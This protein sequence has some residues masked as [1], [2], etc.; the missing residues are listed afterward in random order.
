MKLELINIF[1]KQVLNWKYSGIG[2]FFYFE[3]TFCFAIYFIIPL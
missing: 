1:G 2:F 3:V